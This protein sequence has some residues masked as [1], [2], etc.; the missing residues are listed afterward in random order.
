MVAQA[1]RYAV[2][3]DLGGTKIELGIVD[4]SGR[5]HRAI[6][7]E[8]RV[9]EGPRAIQD[10]IIANIHDLIEQCKIPIIGIGIGA[11]G[12]IH[13]KTGEVIF[14][15]NLNW[16]HVPLQET[17]EK[18]LHLP[19]QIVNDVRAITFGEWLYGA[20]KGCEHLL[21][22]FVGTGIGSGVVSGGR[23]LTGCSNTF[24]EVG[25]MTVDFNGPL[26]TCGKRGCLEVFAGGWGIAARAQEAIKENT[27][28]NGSKMLLKLANDHLDAVTAKIVIQAYQSGNE[29]AKKIIDQAERSLIAGLA[30]M[31]N[32]FNPCRIIL[33]GGLIE[34]LPEFIDSLN[35]G[36]RKIAL[37]AAAESLEIVK[38]KL[39]IEV[40][41]IGA[42]AAIFQS[43][44]T[45]KK[46]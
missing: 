16:H 6:R 14:A 9:H 37:K 8:T 33:G 15:P 23:M 25:H 39:G 3:V 27:E 10:Q 38:A 36:V 4:E 30:S 45:G 11:A 2:G 42:A 31:V 12:Q 22:V 28:K 18:A 1:I 43:I 44:K 7:I 35:E 32:G 21:C 40:G 41:V 46:G 26:C 19:V 29:L 17:M 20:G 5:L 34:G 24:G 13:P